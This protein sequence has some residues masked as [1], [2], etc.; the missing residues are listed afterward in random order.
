MAFFVERIGKAMGYPEF[1]ASDITCFHGIRDVSPQS[2]MY[3]TSFR[4][5][6]IVAFTEGRAPQRAEEEE[7][8]KEEE[9]D[10]DATL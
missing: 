1:Q 5:P 2:H 9:G 7:E 10:D 8:K 6:E 4:L 3:S